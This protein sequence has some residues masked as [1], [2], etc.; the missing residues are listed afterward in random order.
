MKSKPFTVKYIK[1]HFKLMQNEHAERSH[2]KTKEK[3]K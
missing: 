3:D 1:I 2:F